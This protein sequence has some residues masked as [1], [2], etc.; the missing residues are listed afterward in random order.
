LQQPSPMGSRNRE[1][2]ED[3]P[4]NPD[5][6]STDTTEEKKIFKTKPNPK[7][8][9]ADTSHAESEVKEIPRPQLGDNAYWALNSVRRKLKNDVIRAKKQVTNGQDYGAARNPTQSPP[10][11]STESN[12]GAGRR[13]SNDKTSKV[14]ESP[15]ACTRKLEEARDAIF[16]REQSMAA[17]LEVVHEHYEALLAKLDKTAEVSESPYACTRQLEEANYTLFQQEQSMAVRLE[18]VHEHYEAL[19]AKLPQKHE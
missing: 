19:L 14:S 11:K 18:V 7:P 13:N 1:S 15:Y 5:A 17:R 8:R 10:V 16:R 2:H 9:A 3:T 4:D 12:S 6:K